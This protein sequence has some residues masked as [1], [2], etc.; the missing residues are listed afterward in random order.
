MR[1]RS[2]NLLKNENFTF[3]L[4]NE[5]KTL[6]FF[7][8]EVNIPGVNL[9]EIQINHLSQN[10]KRVGDTLNYSQLNVTVICDEKLKAFQ[11]VYNYLIRLKNPETGILDIEKAYFNGNLILTTNKNNPLLNIVFY[12]CWINSISDLQLV[13]TNTEA[14]V[15]TFTITMNFDYYEF[16]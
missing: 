14:N 11:E 4:N 6:E 8:Q 10:Q 2:L 9:G 3:I 1:N 13:T 12:N 16:K 7:V 15:L 5:F